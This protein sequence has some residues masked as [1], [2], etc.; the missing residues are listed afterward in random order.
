LG[1]FFIAVSNSSQRSAL[2][3]KNLELIGRS[4]LGSF[5]KNKGLAASGSGKN[6]NLGSFRQMK[7][8]SATGSF[9][10][11]QFRLAEG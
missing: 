10:D 7:K 11:R 4:E 8:L 5:L 3:K 9:E 2:K 1:S 6:L